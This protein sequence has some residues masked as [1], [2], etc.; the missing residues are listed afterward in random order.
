MSQ[1]KLLM[2]DVHDSWMCRGKCCLHFQ[3]KA[4][5][6]I[7]DLIRVT[8][9]C[10]G[11]VVARL[12]W[13]KRSDLGRN[14]RPVKIH[15]WRLNC[16]FCFF[17]RPEKCVLRSKVRTT[18]AKREM[19]FYKGFEMSIRLVHQWEVLSSISNS[20]KIQKR[21]FDYEGDKKT[22]KNRKWRKR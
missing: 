7:T 13:K 21:P 19:R 2:S 3:D 1:L 22:A 4:M 9:F 10:T 15:G 18:L 17:S 16:K 11:R 12:M 8:R 20:R 14:M 5:K 6:L